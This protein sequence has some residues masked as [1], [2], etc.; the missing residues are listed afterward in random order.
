M[1]GG[2]LGEGRPGGGDARCGEAG[3]SGDRRLE[4]LAGRRDVTGFEGDHAGVVAEQRIA[5]AEAE[6]LR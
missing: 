5:G 2:D 1:R 4:V 6:R 3:V